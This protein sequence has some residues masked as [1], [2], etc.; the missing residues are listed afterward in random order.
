MLTISL[1]SAMVLHSKFKAKFQN[2]KD[3]GNICYK[4]VLWKNIYLLAERITTKNNPQ[5]PLYIKN[6]PSFN[7]LRILNP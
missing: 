1:T 5:Q 6:L 7:L 3:L 4:K 2:I